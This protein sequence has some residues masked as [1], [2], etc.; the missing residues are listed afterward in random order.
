MPSIGSEDFIS[1]DWDRSQLGMSVIDITRPG[2]NGHAFREQG[3][4]SR[5]TRAITSANYSSNNAMKSTFDTFKSLYQG[6][7]R[8]IEDDFGTTFDAVMIVD[9]QVLE[10]VYVETVSGGA[11]DVDGKYLQTLQWMLR[12]T[13]VN[14]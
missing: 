8:D 3:Q 14:P 7:F 12:E 4:K 6:D 2:T 9:V 5:T 13:K 11:P 10:E 1:I